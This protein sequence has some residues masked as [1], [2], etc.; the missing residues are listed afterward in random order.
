MEFCTVL[1]NI[2]RRESYYIIQSSC[3]QNFISSAQPTVK[4]I[5]KTMVPVFFYYYYYFVIQSRFCQFIFLLCMRVFCTVS[6]TNRNYLLEPPEHYASSTA[7]INSVSIVYTVQQSRH[8]LGTT[9]GLGLN[10]A[11][12]KIYTMIL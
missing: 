1:G 12:Q 10:P 9:A 6:E 5:I 7:D 11:G 3:N 4:T 2:T 8:L